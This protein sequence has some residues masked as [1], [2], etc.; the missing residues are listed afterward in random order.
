MA[1][2]ELKTYVTPCRMK[3]RWC[4]SASG[5]ANT[6]CTKS[7]WHRSTGSGTARVD[8]ENPHAG[9]RDVIPEIVASI[10]LEPVVKRLFGNDPVKV[11]MLGGASMLVA[12]MTTRVNDVF[13]AKQVSATTSWTMLGSRAHL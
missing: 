13:V 11:V 7:F 4:V 1:S 10:S 3:Q 2:H 5:C 8:F 9:G 12:A 6:A